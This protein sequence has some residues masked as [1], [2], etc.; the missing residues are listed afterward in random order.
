[1]KLT[2]VFMMALCGACVGCSSPKAPSGEQIQAALDKAV[3]KNNPEATAKLTD[4]K[5][6]RGKYVDVKFACTNCVLEDRAGVKKTVSSAN[7]T[8]EVLLDPQDGKWKLQGGLV[9]S[10]DGS[11]GSLDLWGQTF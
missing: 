7:G 5:M 6:D 3:K 11:S 2:L 9:I 4:I 10:E 1:M 8:A